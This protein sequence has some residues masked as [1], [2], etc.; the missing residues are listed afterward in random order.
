MPDNIP[1]IIQI[2]GNNWY[3]ETRTGFD[4]PFPTKQEACQFQ[5]LLI[6]SNAARVEFAGLQYLPIE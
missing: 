6:C 4:G 3:V 1:H 5:D 2:S